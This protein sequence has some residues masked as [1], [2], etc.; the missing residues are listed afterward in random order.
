MSRSL[1]HFLIFL[2]LY[3][4]FLHESP[5]IFTPFLNRTVSPL[6]LSFTCCSNPAI[7]LLHREKWET[8]KGLGER[9]EKE[10]NYWQGCGCFFFLSSY[11]GGR[12]KKQLIEWKRL[13]F[14]NW[15]SFK[16]RVP[17][18]KRHMA[19]IQRTRRLS[20]MIGPRWLWDKHENEVYVGPFLVVFFYFLFLF[21][22]VS[23]NREV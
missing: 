10:G 12:R 9:E 7:L 3:H 1:S 14:E 18:H 4:P 15:S 16:E 20:Y 6:A 2:T 19:I 5:T 21:F 17:T 11:S 23:S 22:K 13:I 8:Q